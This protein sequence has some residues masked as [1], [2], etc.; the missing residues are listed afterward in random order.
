[1]GGCTLEAVEYLCR[2]IHFDEVDSL[3]LVSSLVDKNLLQIVERS[4]DEAR[5]LMLE[6]IREYGE[7]CLHTSGEFQAVREAHTKYYL[8][9]VE[10][11]E[12]ELRK[13]NQ[14][15]WL[16]RLEQ[17]HDN[18]RAAL[19]GLLERQHAEKALRLASSLWNFWLIRAHQSEGYQWLEDALNL[20]IS[21]E[22]P[23]PV[24]ARSYYA[25][26]ILAESQGLYQRS[27]ECWERALEQYRAVQDQHGIAAT[28]NKLGG[29]Y[30]RT[31]PTEAHALFEQ[32]L[33][34]A[35]QEQDLYIISDVLA[36]FAA[37]EFAQGYHLEKA[38]AYCEESLEIVRNLQDRRSIAYR[39]SDLGQILTH[40]GK[41]STA[42]QYLT[43]SLSIYRE[44]G[45]RVSMAF[46]MIS[47]GMA[48]LYLGDYS[49]AQTWL[50]E[51]F[52]VS[53]ELGNQNKLAQYLGTLGEAALYQKGEEPPAR[54]LIEQS[55]AIFS[56][57]DNEEGIASKLH[58]LGCIEFN[59]GNYMLARTL[60][61]ESLT[62]MRRLENRAMTAASLH[63]LGQVEAHMGNHAIARTSMEESLAI[64][65][66]QSDRQVLPTRC[67]QL[68]LVEL[69]DGKNERA[70][71]LFNEGIQVAKEIGDRRQLADALCMQALLYLSEEDYT[72][73]QKLLEEGYNDTDIQTSFYRLADMG[74]LAL[75]QG[76]LTKARQLIEESLATSLQIRNRWFVASC[77]ER[78]G[79]VFVAQSRYTQAARFWGAASAIRKAIQAPIPPIEVKQYERAQVQTRQQLGEARFQAAWLEGE[80]MTPEE[81]L[82]QEKQDEAHKHNNEKAAPTPES[83]QLDDLTEREI[84]VLRYVATGLTN[85]QIAE[86]LII[87]PR[88]VQAHLTSIYSKISVTSRSAATRYALE[89]HLT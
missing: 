6:T 89:H 22:V 4:N 60:L 66:A 7:E 81:V 23:P 49:A 85:A 87:S 51:S 68:A 67:I 50:S 9:L 46:V 5:L 78:L 70:R 43:E 39:L 2:V 32:S 19:K 26:G 80:Q 58:S 3:T 42:Y 52:T 71:E 27:T 74:R 61:S 75:I 88:T 31:T 59:Q 21:N 48:A 38:R 25:T 76:D 13:A 16:E 65:R 56:E 73:A 79:E 8:Q 57:T 64:S 72:T 53:R 10:E 44:V 84:E 37:E 34:I 55:L 69:N 15:Q 83:A 20:A 12:P 14:A 18:L 82:S 63:M 86:Q 36:F 28:L 33:A 29:A 77:L 54:A 1:M 24:I 47:L 17:E 30:A 11:A 62:I 35:R 41:Y 45:D 40:L